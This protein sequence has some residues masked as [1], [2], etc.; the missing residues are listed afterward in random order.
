MTGYIDATADRAAW[1]FLGVADGPELLEC[2]GAVDR[3]LVH[4][5]GLE[6]VVGGAVAGH[7]TFLG[8][9]R[10][11]IVGAVGLDDVV[12]NERTASPS[13]NGEVAVSVG[14]VGTRV[15]NRPGL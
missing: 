9:G 8:G 7:R 15:A 10:G 13:I 5:R 6:D 11:G 1:V 14:C 4:A 3:G 12:F 2:L